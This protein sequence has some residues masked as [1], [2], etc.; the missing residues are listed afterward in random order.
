M[1]RTHL[2]RRI[3]RE[4]LRDSITFHM[5][6]DRAELETFYAQA[7]W[8]FHLTSLDSSP[9]VV[10]EALVRGLPVVG[11]RHP[12]I[13]VVDPDDRFILFADAF[14][15]DALLDRLIAEKA[16]PPGHAARASVGRA[17]IA[18]NFSSET[19]SERY[20]EL[21]CHLLSERRE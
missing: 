1:D 9:R 8:L 10:L 21:Y 12:G 15:P 7:D 14:E 13:T 20:V 6:V 19:I 4:D 18:E 5:R 17:Y 11:S 16:D 2:R 3:E